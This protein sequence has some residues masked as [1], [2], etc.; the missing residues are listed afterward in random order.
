[1][2][3]SIEHLLED[4]GNVVVIRKTDTITTALDLMTE[5]DFSQLPVV[6]ENGQL[7]GMVT[8]ESIMRGA[9]SFDI[10]LDKLSVSDALVNAPLHYREDDLFDLLD[11][12]KVTNAVV[13]VEPKRY[14]IGISRATR[15]TLRNRTEDRCTLKTLSSL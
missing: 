9:R 7:L 11:E 10:K 13:I 5:N 15:F 12:L 8:Y 3:Y 6:D 14:V 4:Q 2:P 1:M